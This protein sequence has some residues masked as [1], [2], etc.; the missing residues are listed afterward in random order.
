MS[1]FN[2]V[3][4]LGN[5]TRD[6]EIRYSPKGQAIG[7]LGIAVNRKYK[8]ESGEQKEEVTFVDVDCFGKQAELIGQYLKKGAPLFAEG[9]LK[10]DSWDDKATG[11]KRYALRVVLENFQFIGGGKADGGEPSAPA[12]RATRPSVAPAAQPSSQEVDNSD[13]PF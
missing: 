13:I 3:I 12:T 11:Q 7:K 5:L 10:L 1:S 8:T 2:K 9:R 4:L 6:P